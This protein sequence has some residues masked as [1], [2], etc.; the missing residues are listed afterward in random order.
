MKTI[1]ILPFVDSNLEF[2]PDADKPTHIQISNISS[3]SPFYPTSG[4]HKGKELSMVRTSVGT[5]F[6]I[7]ETVNNFL[8]RCKKIK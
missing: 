5:V 4:R 1:A 8:T 2:T 6:V 3:I 7:D